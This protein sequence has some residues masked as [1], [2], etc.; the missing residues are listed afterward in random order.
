MR[1]SPW[2]LSLVLLGCGGARAGVGYV[3]EDGGDG[4]EPCAPNS[5]SPCVCADGRSGQSTCSAVGVAG[6]CLCGA[7]T[8]DGGVAGLDVPR[9][10][11]PAGIDVG[12]AIDVPTVGPGQVG[13]T[14]TRL[15]DCTSGVCLP[16]GR[17]SR[18]CGGASDC[19]TS[20]TCSTLPGLGPVCSCTPRGAETCND[21]D[22]D[23]DGLVDEGTSRCSGRCVD[24]ANDATNCGGCG[25]VCGGG[26]GCANG[27]CVCP[28]S[29]SL[30]CGG[31][32]VDPRTSN[33][34]CG[35]CGNVCGTG[36][37]CVS[38]TCQ[39][40]G[41]CPT[42]CSVS[43]DCTSCATPGETGTYCCVSGLCIYMS[44]ST[45]NAPVDS[46]LPSD[47]GLPSD[48]GSGGGTGSDVPNG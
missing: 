18:A 3:P 19:P 26:T 33:A 40:V 46:G 21:V 42:S 25:V 29:A 5:V 14:C 17:C 15:T 43:T 4:G 41:S 44:G 13:A 34:N 16:S 9:I 20:W 8:G 6:A 39:R 38:G 23:C 45:C 22:D 37:S 11:A 7:D 30:S 1:A 48:T 28:P 2:F 12:S 24:L 27:A 47:L 32:C 31:R 36:T 10:D 35:A